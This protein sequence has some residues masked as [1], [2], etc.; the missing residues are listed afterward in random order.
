MYGSARRKLIQA[1]GI[2]PGRKPYTRRTAS[3]SADA[4]PGITDAGSSTSD[5]STDPASSDPSP[6]AEEGEAPKK[7]RKGRRTAV[8]RRRKA[9]EMD[10]GDK[11]GAADEDDGAGIAV[12]EA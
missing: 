8:Q 4:V 10:D 2:D 7:P 6:A 1:T 5:V 12:A 9:C 11:D 3:A